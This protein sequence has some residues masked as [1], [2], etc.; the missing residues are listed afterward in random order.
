MGRGR[1]AHSSAVGGRERGYGQGRKAQRCAR[2]LHQL[3]GSVHGW[4]F[5][6]P[7]DG[8][9]MSAHSC[10]NGSSQQRVNVVSVRRGAHGIVPLGDGPASC[11]QW[12]SFL[13]LGLCPWGLTANPSPALSTE[14][15][16]SPRVPSSR[17]T[18]SHTDRMLG[19]SMGHAAVCLLVPVRVV[20]ACRLF[21]SWATNRAGSR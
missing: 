9:D 12:A 3:M 19:R 13:C 16:P 1:F 8:W 4:W 21:A 17:S 15:M 5:W 2:A 18:V 6:S 7:G 10:E 20:V 11:S 14:D